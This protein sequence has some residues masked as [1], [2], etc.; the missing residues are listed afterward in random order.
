[1]IH[2]DEHGPVDADL[3][4]HGPEWWAMGGELCTCGHRLDKHR[5]QVDNTDASAGIH[6]PCE[7]C[8]CQDFELAP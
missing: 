4:E 7:Q 1:M 8:A 2:H 5:E 6:M 3:R